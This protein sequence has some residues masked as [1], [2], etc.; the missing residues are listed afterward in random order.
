MLLHGM[1]NGNVLHLNPVHHT[2]L[3]HAGGSYSALSQPFHSISS[4][5]S[6]AGPSVA[7]A[8][9][10]VSHSWSPFPR[11]TGAGMSKDVLVGKVRSGHVLGRGIHQ[12]WR[13][14]SSHGSRD[15]Q[16]HML[17]GKVRGGHALGRGIH[18]KWR[19]SPSHGSRDVQRHML[20]GRKRRARTTAEET[21]WDCTGRVGLAARLVG[22]ES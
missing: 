5:V 7:D 12:K 8:L 17:V 19:S 3:E 21:R 13:S 9:G 11:P 20:V 1:A 2:L 18:Q 16:R 6:S 22:V 14:P 15:V 10:A 4:Y